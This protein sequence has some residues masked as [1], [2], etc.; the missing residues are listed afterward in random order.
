MAGQSPAATLRG[1]ERSQGAGA[2]FID[3]LNP[4]TRVNP[5]ERGSDI[6][7]TGQTLILPRCDLWLELELLSS[8]ISHG[9]EA[10]AAG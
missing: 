5:E 7:P 9:T 10:S 8:T 1:Q 6:K 3:F 2:V 4:R